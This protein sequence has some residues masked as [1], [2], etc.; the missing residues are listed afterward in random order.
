MPVNSETD[1]HVILTVQPRISAGSLSFVELPAGMLDDS[2]TF[3]G[4]AAKEISEECGLEI[5]ESDLLN[6][7]E[8]AISASNDGERLQAAVYPSAGGC[9]EYIPIFLWQKRI[10]RE[11][12]QGWQG[13]LTG[14]RDEGERITLKLA[15]L[16]DVWKV[17]GRDGKVLAGYSLYQGLR[18]EG[19]I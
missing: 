19:K 5:S 15:K 12:L 10:P 17:G 8:L 11:Q 13:K 6:M 16:E 4:A 7:T 18:K 1:K 2:G 9:D 3:A 14:L